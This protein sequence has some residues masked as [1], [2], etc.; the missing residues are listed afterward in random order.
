MPGSV[1]EIDVINQETGLYF[2]IFFYCLKPSIDGFLNGCRPFFSIDSA[3]LNGRWND[4]LPS[5]TAL[6]GAQ[7][8]VSSCI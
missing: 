8:D 4:H 5:T 7:L 3:A 6:D 1:V 2:H